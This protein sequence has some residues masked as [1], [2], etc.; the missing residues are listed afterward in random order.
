MTPSE[1]EKSGNK[2]KDSDN[3]K[4]VILQRCPTHRTVHMPDE[5]CPECEKEEK[6]S[7]S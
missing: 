7:A 3:D 6:T 2:S 1:N 4:T 5:R